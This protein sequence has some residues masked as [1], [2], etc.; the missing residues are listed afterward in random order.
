MRRALRAV[1]AMALLPL[2][3]VITLL[4]PHSAAAA[5][6]TQVTGFGNAAGT[7]HTLPQAGMPAYA[8]IFPGLDGGAQPPPVQS[9]ALHAVGASKCLDVPNA[10]TT[11]GT[12]PQ[13]RD[14]DGRPGQT[15]TRT[16]S[17]QLIV[18]ADSTP[19][20]LDAY[21]H[22]TTAGTK[23]QI[24]P[25]NGGTNQQWLLNSV[26][27]TVTGVQSGLCLDVAGASTA[28]GAAVELWTC[29]GQTNQQWTLS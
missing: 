7:G 6:L 9:G 16:V 21:D 3:A 22:Q 19:M 28:D 12:Q 29:N 23:V 1:L 18:Y 11:A 24:W 4:A 13:I 5:G 10:S 17:N 27:H 14:C 15:W 26:T 2:A 25:C 20:C 8:T